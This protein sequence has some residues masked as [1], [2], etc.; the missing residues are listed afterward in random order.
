MTRVRLSVDVEPELRRR[1][2]VAAASRD[3]SV[4]EW[5]EGVLQRELGRMNEDVAWMGG[6]SRAWESLGRMSGM[7]VNWKMRRRSG[8]S[9]DPVC[10]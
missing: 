2:R 7:R 4:K 5:L 8:T 10:E 1:V 3:Q 6:I 9:R